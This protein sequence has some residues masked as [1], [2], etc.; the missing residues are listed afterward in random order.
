MGETH[1]TRSSVFLLGPP[2][3]QREPLMGMGVQSVAWQSWL[4]CSSLPRL[5]APLN[6][7]QAA[8]HLTLSTTVGRHCPF[9]FPVKKE[10]LRELKTFAQV[11]TTGK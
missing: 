8:S 5:A 2:P 6:E 9:H 11:H 4:S 1:R 3:G 10:R 7:W